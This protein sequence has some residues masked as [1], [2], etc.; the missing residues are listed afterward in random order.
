MSFMC[1]SNGTEP[2][3]FLM[4]KVTALFDFIVQKHRK[5]RDALSFCRGRWSEFFCHCLYNGGQW[6]LN[7]YTIR[8][9]VEIDGR[10]KHEHS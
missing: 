8:H 3:F 1:Y 2:L 5:R 10:M 4:R 7:F 9:A 6:E